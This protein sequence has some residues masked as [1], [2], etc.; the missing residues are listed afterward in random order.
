M[1]IRPIQREEATVRIFAE[2]DII[3]VEGNACVSGD[4][5]FDREVERAILRRL[6]QG[7]IW[8][9]ATVTVTVCWG[10]FSASDYLGC[11]CYED[12]ADFCQSG[13]YY[14]DM[15]EAALEALNSVIHKTYQDLKTRE[16]AA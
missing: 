10:P 13:G 15:V 7:D 12:E 14:D 4:D 3:P 11:C 1:N 2:Q 6:D 5:A 8:A 16:P 9:W